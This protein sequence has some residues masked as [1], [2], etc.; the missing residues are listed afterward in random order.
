MMSYGLSFSLILTFSQRERA[1][2]EGSPKVYQRYLLH[3]AS[4]LNP[5]LTNY[6]TTSIMT[7]KKLI[8]KLTETFSPS[9]SEGAIRDVILNEI[10]GLA[11]DIRVDAMGNLI[12]R[13]G[14]KTGQGK[15]IMVAAHMDEIGLIVTHVD[16]NGFVRFTNLGTPFARYLPGG[17]VRFTNGTL[18]IIDSEPPEGLHGIVKPEKMFIDVGAKSRKD[19]PVKIGDM[20]AFERP[21]VEIGDRLVAKSFDDRIGC[22]ILIETMRRLK[23]SPHELYFVFTVQEEVGTRGAA[24]ATFGID[25]EIGLSVDIVPTGDTPKGWNTHTE[26]G[27]G[28]AILIKDSGLIADPRIVAW[29]TGSAEKAKIPY[30]RNV[31]MRGGTDAMAMQRSRAGVM[32]GSIGVPT[33]Y[34]HSPSEM[35]DIN[36]VENSIKLLME[37]VS[38]PIQL[39]AP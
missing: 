3:N 9:G 29:M 33:R 18:G 32:T 28:P 14:E 21:F 37:L 12:A 24:T 26:L 36:D 30:Q 16:E 38:K 25:P 13:K 7:D 35:I 15:R 19:C 5:S 4:Y 17:H 31:Q 39:D 6:G 2:G 11:D 1:E 34:A 10:K 8:K 20:A 27:K 23:S 22:V